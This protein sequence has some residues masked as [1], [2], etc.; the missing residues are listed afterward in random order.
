M[1]HFDADVIIIGGGPSGVAASLELKRQGIDRVVLL[2][3]EASLG[4]ATRHCSHSPFGMREFGRLYLGSAYGRRLQAEAER[5]GVDVR[6]HHSVVTLGEA[7]RPRRHVTAWRGDIASP[8][9]DAGHR[10][11]RDAALGKTGFRRPAD[12]RADHRRVAG[13]CR[14][15]RVDALQTSVDCRFGTRLLFRRADLPHPWRAARGDDRT[16][17]SHP[18]ARAPFTLFPKLAGIP[19]HTGTD[20]VD[21][22]GTT[23][24][25]AVTIRHADGRTETIACDGV[26][27]SGHFTPESALLMQSSL[28]VASGST[29]PAIDQAGRMANPLYFAGGNVLRAIETGG[30]AFREGRGVGAAIATDLARSRATSVP[31]PVSFDAPVKLVV[32]NLLRRGEAEPA[33]RDFQLR[34]LRPARGRLTLEC[35]G[36]AVWGRVGAWWP[37]RRILVPI[38][39]HAAE[40]GHIHFRFEEQ[41]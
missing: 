29:G 26:L 16:G 30:W 24:V 28:G 25:E 19:F 33:F 9:R 23:R 38:P 35:D 27:F 21:I 7:G 41:G 10:R 8:A 20:I 11:A 40:A 12:W 32:P 22:R 39:P 17:I 37:E 34:F 18:L 6:P 15:S 31:V 1:S 4:G 5:A 2:D 13:L 14:L 3:R 36:R